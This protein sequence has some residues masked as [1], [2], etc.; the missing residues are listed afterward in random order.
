MADSRPSSWN[1]FIGN[2]MDHQVR[3]LDDAGTF[4][5]MGIENT[6]WGWNIAWGGHY[7]CCHS[8]HKTS[9]SHTPRSH[10]NSRDTMG[11]VLIRYFDA[12]VVDLLLAYE[13]VLQNFTAEDKSKI[14]CIPWKI[15]YPDWSRMLQS[16]CD[17]I[18]PGQS[19]FLSYA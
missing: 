12:S 16:L 6:G 15:S 19:T 17:G 2:N 8:W 7:R 11:K 1:Q 4:H 9:Q 10:C 13:A 3:T 5:G 14:F 18:Y